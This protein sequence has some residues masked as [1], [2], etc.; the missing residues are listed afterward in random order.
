MSKIAILGDTHFAVRSGS[1]LFSDYFEKFYENVFFPYLKENNITAIIQTGDL[2]DERKRVNN[3]G[4]YEARRFFFDKIQKEDI[5]MYVLLGNHDVAY[6]DT[7]RVNSPSLLLNDYSHINIIDSPLTIEVEG[8]NICFI[9]WICKENEEQCLNELRTSRSNVC[10]GH[11]EISGFA[12]YKGIVGHGGMDSSL[13]D[14]F[15][16]VF[17]GH[18]H[19]RSTKRNIHY[20]GTPY[21]LTWSDYGDPKGFHIFDLDSQKLDFIKNPYKMFNKIYY[22]DTEEDQVNNFM[23][24][25]HKMDLRNSYAKL[26]VKN[27][28]NVYLFDKFLEQLEKEEPFDLAI[29]EDVQDVFTEEMIDIDESEDT[30]TTIYKFVDISTNKDYDPERVKKIL[31]D[32]YSEAISIQI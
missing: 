8:K 3:S 15:E 23:G 29:I 1:L 28:N 6:K 32:L 26:V 30:L 22:D 4:L 18:Y 21:E 31:S 14:R 24:S 10:I 12:M 5:K 11:F 2:F 19:H 9:P 25:F 27:K 17:S 16:Y 7:L 20:V 13:F